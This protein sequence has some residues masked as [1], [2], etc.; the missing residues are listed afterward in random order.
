MLKQGF[1]SYCYQPTDV[2][3]YATQILPTEPSVSE[4]NNNLSNIDVK[5]D[6]TSATNSEKGTEELSTKISSCDVQKVCDCVLAWQGSLS[7]GKSLTIG[8]SKGKSEGSDNEDEG[9][10][11]EDMA[12]DFVESMEDEFVDEDSQEELIDEDLS[13]EDSVDELMKGYE[14]SLDSLKINGVSCEMNEDSHEKSSGD[15]GETVNGESPSK[16]AKRLESMETETEEISEPKLAETNE[17]KLSKKQLK[18]VEAAERQNKKLKRQLEKKSLKLEQEK[19]V[20]DMRKSE[21]KQVFDITGLDAGQILHQIESTGSFYVEDQND[22]DQYDIQDEV[23][24]IVY[25]GEK[26]NHEKK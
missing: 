1:E 16:V 10:D 15:L 17:P 25:S 11:D 8:R 2:G 4:S 23:S 5:S 6:V 20:C 9:I 12:D 13:Q 21:K 19:A 26:F 22:F 14:E 3:H 24:G 18:K 7:N